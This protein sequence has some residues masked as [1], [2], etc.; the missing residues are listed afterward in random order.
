MCVAVGCSLL[1]CLSCAIRKSLSVHISK[2]KTCVCA[3]FWT[4]CL[5]WCTFCQKNT[6]LSKSLSVQSL[7]EKKTFL[8]K[9]VWEE[10]GPARARYKEWEQ[11]ETEHARHGTHKARETNASMSC[12]CLS[13]CIGAS[14]AMPHASASMAMPHACAHLCLV[15][16]P[17]AFHPPTNDPQ[18]KGAKNQRASDARRWYTC[19]S[20]QAAW[21]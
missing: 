5:R 16:M 10:G 21:L 2:I 6:I 11:E 9:C 13:L 12:V 1:Q 19:S 20:P 4:K 14:M 8:S 15:H 17:L 3:L 7:S 18:T